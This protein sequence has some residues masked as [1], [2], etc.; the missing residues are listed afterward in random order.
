[1]TRVVSVRMKQSSGDTKKVHYFL[2]KQIV[3]FDA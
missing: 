2:S 1:M 3:S